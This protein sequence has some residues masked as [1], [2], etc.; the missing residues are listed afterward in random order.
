MSSGTLLAGCRI[1]ARSK[2]SRLISALFWTDLRSGTHRDRIG[3]HAAPHQ[4]WRQLNCRVW[5]EDRS[6]NLRGVTAAAE[7]H[8]ACASVIDKHTARIQSA[9][10]ENA[11]ECENQLIRDVQDKRASTRRRQGQR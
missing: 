8:T 9:R 7:P 10:N 3:N 4:A 2:I 11:S 6:I 5:R 1:K